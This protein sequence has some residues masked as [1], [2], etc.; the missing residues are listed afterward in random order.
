[1]WR[2]ILRT[3][4]CEELTA[5]GWSGKGMCG[6]NF[7]EQ[8]S[9][10]GSQFSDFLPFADGNFGTPSGKAELYSETLKRRGWIRSLDFT[11][12]DESRHSSQASSFRWNCW[13][14]RRTTSSTPRF[15]NLPVIQEMEEVGLLEIS[16][17]D[18]RGASIV[19]GDAVRV[20]NGRG[21]II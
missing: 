4:G 7:E 8:F 9:A 14:A 11:P 6:L 16:A 10:S 21:E 17:A 2:L 5:S 19:D 13:R 20:F 3:P 1:M 12:P 18:A 15:R